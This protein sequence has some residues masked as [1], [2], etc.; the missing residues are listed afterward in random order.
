MDDGRWE[1]RGDEVGK[2][3][4]DFL[5]KVWDGVRDVI[6]AIEVNAELGEVRRDIENE[7]STER[8][9]L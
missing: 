7:V 3:V 1:S 6:A 4:A 9:G 2:T 8:R 5:L